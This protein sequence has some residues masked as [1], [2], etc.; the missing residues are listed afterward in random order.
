MVFLNTGADPYVLDEQG[1]TCMHLAVRSNNIA[2]FV[3]LYEIGLSLN[4]ADYLGNTPL[5]LSLLERREEFS[6][7]I[8]ALSNALNI[9][10]ENGK[11]PLHLAAELGNYRVCRRLIAFKARIDVLDDEERLAKDYSANTEIKKLVIFI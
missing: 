9:R 5:H 4:Q 2:L 8:L 1:R 7:L 11:T 6:L 3:K 10:G